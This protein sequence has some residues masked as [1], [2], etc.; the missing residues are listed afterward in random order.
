MIRKIFVLLILIF[1][2]NAY[3][4]CESSFA[5]EYLRDEQPTPDSVD[6]LESPLGNS[7]RIIPRKKVLFPRLRDFLKNL[8]PVLSDTQLELNIRSFY[9]DRSNRNGSE[10]TAWALGGSVS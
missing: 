8:P 3:F 6:K 1:Q 10:S 2:I 4:V 9:F 5:V 7:F